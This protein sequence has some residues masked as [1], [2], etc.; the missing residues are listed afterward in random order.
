M[1]AMAR[2]NF[3]IYT[4]IVLMMRASN[5]TTEIRRLINVDI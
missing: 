4:F 3:Q 1:I 2:L 5:G